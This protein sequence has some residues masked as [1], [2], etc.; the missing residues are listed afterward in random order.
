MTTWLTSTRKRSSK[1]N[2]TSVIGFGPKNGV[3]AT[4]SSSRGD[5]SSPSSSRK[6]LPMSGG[7]TASSSSNRS[8]LIS[9][10]SD[11]LSLQM[12]HYQ[13]K[14]SQRNPWA[15]DMQTSEINTRLLRSTCKMQRAQTTQKGISLTSQM[16]RWDLCSETMPTLLHNPLDCNVWEMTISTMK[17]F[18][19]SGLMDTVIPIHINFR[20]VWKPLDVIWQTLR[21]NLDC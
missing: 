15:T 11:I 19:N 6:T 2:S 14:N 8:I 5:S 17:I 12:T 1:R 7:G 3:Q 10:V 4:S 16:S 13:C 18:T 21:A 20:S 9:G